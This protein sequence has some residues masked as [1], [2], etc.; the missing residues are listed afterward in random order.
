MSERLTRE[1]AGG[2]AASKASTHPQLGDTELGGPGHGDNCSAPYATCCG[3][4]RVLAVTACSGQGYF[5]SASIR[6][7]SKGG[8]DVKRLLA[9]AFCAA[10]VV[11]VSSG[12]ALAGEGE[13]PSRHF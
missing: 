4:R 13:G 1:H 3:A 8:V 6:R 7:R 11:G 2:E 5:R 9:I 10:A 12:A